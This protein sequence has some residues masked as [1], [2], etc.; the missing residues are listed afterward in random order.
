MIYY[1]SAENQC[2]RQSLSHECQ[3]LPKEIGDQYTCFVCNTKFVL[4]EG[5]LSNESIWIP[6]SDIGGHY[7]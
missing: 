1:I 2:C 3:L 7:G 4:Q 6:I 5:K